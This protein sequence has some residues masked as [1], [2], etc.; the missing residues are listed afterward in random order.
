MTQLAPGAQQGQ[1]PDNELKQ[2]ANALKESAKE[3]AKEK[4]E[5]GRDQAV[6]AAQSTGS[7]IETAADEL[8][9][10]PDTPDWMAGMLN[11]AAQQI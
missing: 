6:A 3:R 1:S 8:R 4:T 5:H 9:S 10:D 7:A 2:D 11:S